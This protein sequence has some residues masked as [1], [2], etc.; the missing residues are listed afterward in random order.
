MNQTSFKVNMFHLRLH[1]FSK[2]H[3]FE[4]QDD[5]SCR[6]TSQLINKDNFNGAI[7]RV[8][9]AVLL[10]SQLFSVVRSYRLVNGYGLFER[11]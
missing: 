11:S 7:F 6:H 5:R 10:M 9:T 2:T 4:S 1:V 8:F 3:V